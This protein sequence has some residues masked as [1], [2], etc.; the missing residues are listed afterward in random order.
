MKTPRY[1]D[2]HVVVHPGTSTP[3]VWF[4][5]RKQL[6]RGGATD[7]DLAEFDDKVR[8]KPKAADARE[9]AREFLNVYVGDPDE[10]RERVKKIRA[11]QKKSS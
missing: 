2:V 11:G 5:A 9:A 4:R 7:A 10:I 3:G 6:E 8:A 1:P